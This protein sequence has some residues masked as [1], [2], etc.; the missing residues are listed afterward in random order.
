MKNFICIFEL[1]WIKFY[2]DLSLASHE[3]LAK[4][5]I[6][7]S[8]T[9]A[10]CSMTNV[11]PTLIHFIRFHGDVSRV[12]RFCV[13]LDAYFVFDHLVERRRVR[14]SVHQNGPVE[15]WHQEIGLTLQQSRTIIFDGKKAKG[16]VIGCF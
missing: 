12:R 7:H 3:N 14:N 2:L 9:T 1:D 13:N 10:P 6:F 15:T 4:K 8:L 16:H 11:E 5:T